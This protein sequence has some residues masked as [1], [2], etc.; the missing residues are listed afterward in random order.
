MALIVR[1]QM[2]APPP[3]P[4]PP[5]P[6]PSGLASLTLGKKLMVGGAC[7]AFGIAIWRVFVTPP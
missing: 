2:G 3:P 6:P 5:A 4:P 1:E 7:L